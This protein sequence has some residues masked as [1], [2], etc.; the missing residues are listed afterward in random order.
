MITPSANAA[1]SGQRRAAGAGA[2]SMVWVS[3]RV[4]T[5]PSA[6]APAA[7]QASRSGGAYAAGTGDGPAPR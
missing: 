4:A 2:W 3:Q 7:H 5:T 6:A 1:S